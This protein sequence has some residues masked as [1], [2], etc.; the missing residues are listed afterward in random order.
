MNYLLGFAAIAVLLFINARLEQWQRKRKIEKVF[1]E[2]QPKIIEQFYESYFKE[3]GIPFHVVGGVRTILEEQLSADLSCLTDTDD[4]SKNLSFFWDY[5]S[6]A[7]VEIICA[8]EDKFGI[9][10]SDSEAQKAHTID[11]IVT[12]VSGKLELNK[13]QNEQ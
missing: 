2:R 13:S 3:K 12:L 9:K 10:I 11:D 8:L 6:M 5:D 1:S 4:F 7:D